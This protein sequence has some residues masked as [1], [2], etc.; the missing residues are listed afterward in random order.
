MKK[1][2]YFLSVMIAFTACKSYDPYQESDLI[3][4]ETEQKLDSL[5]HLD[6]E[7]VELYKGL[8][9]IQEF[10]ENLVKEKKELFK[11]EKL[12]TFKSEI[13]AFKEFEDYGKIKDKIQRNQRIKYDRIMD[14]YYWKDNLNPYSIFKLDKD[15]DYL[16][17]TKTGSLDFYSRKGSL[18]YE[19][20]NDLI[21]FEGVD[22]PFFIGESTGK[23]FSLVNEDML[24]ATFTKGDENLVVLGDFEAMDKNEFYKFNLSIVDYNRI[25]ID[26]EEYSCEIKREKGYYRSYYD[27][28]IIQLYNIPNAKITDERG[29]IIKKGENVE[30][31]DIPAITI[32][33]SLGKDPNNNNHFDGIASLVYHYKELWWRKFK[34]MPKDMNEFMKE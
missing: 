11:D 6:L 5:Y 15:I 33:L 25:M 30:Q 31:E 14:G 21:Y 26:N 4:Q 28:Y 18:K 13:I 10:Q 34:D 7:D 23:G 9:S 2:I 27:E 1:A 12:E 16:A 32:T 22:S 8:K 29:I 17:E 24:V 19:I 20:K 3:N